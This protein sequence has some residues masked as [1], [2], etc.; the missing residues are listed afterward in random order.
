MTV[1]PIR[2]TS[3]SASSRNSGV[4]CLGGFLLVGTGMFAGKAF[5]H[6]D[7]L[8]WLMKTLLT[9]RFVNQRE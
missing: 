6:V 9:L 8:M 7:A 5:L 4:C 3:F 2:Y 1:T